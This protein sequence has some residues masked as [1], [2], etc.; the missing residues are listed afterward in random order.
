MS[1]LSA[2]LRTHFACL[3]EP[4]RR[5]VRKH[6]LINILFISLCALLSG[7]DTF[8]D[9]AR[10]AVNHQDWLKERIDIK[11]GLPSHDTIGRVF[12]LLDTDA[13]S[14]CFNGWIKTLTTLPAT[15]EHKQ[16][17][18]DGKTIKASF[19]TATGQKAI[20]LVRAF[21]S[22]QRI[23]LDQ[24]K[25]TEK[26][27]EITAIPALLCRLDL[28]GCLVSADA[29][30]CQKKIAEQIIEQR[31][32]YLLSLKENHRSLYERACENIAD[33]REKAWQIPFSVLRWQSVEKYR[34]AVETRRCYLVESADFLDTEKQWR[35]LWGVALV[36]RE[37]RRG[38]TST[39][40][41]RMYLTSLRDAAKV[42]QGCRRHW[43]I[44]NAVHWVLDV[45]FLEDACRVRK[46]NAGVNLSVLRQVCLS[47]LRQETNSGLSLRAK[48]K[49]ASW[50]V[51]YLETL[52]ATNQ[53][54]M[55]ICD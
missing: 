36:E 6:P 54:S 34:G 38:K 24:E 8:T 9:I 27:N 53:Q 14:D 51:N 5:Q 3:P 43:G 39:V 49:E 10:W 28:T 16:V 26:S 35:G 15:S 32:D 19:D 23:V 22:E 33:W 1:L 40:S 20:H 4:R 44:E 30:G 37:I 42:L 31:G 48:R 7:A 13:F 52:L 12:A 45:V 50:N 55:T 29:M 21:A 46:D 47:L 25:V 11:Q 17:C 2:S 18:L 41:Q